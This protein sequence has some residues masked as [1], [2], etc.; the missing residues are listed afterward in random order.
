MN[1][2]IS[3][4]FCSSLSCYAFAVDEV[5][6]HEKLGN[7]NPGGE[8]RLTLNRTGD[9]YKA[10]LDTA[11]PKKLKLK[12][13]KPFHHVMTFYQ[14]H[15]FGHIAEVLSYEINQPEIGFATV[16]FRC[17]EGYPRRWKERAGEFC[18]KAEEHMIMTCKFVFEKYGE[19]VFK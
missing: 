10:I 14:C 15:Q 9:V 19:N 1:K 16:S 3:I 7:Y 6:R 11:E 12:K 5:I 2:L 4:L 18:A 17:K 13:T 8:H